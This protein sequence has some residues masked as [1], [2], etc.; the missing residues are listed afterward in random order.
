[1]GR[2]AV[3]ALLT[4]GLL[5][6]AGCGGSSASSMTTQT[7]GAADDPHTKSPFAAPLLP[8]SVQNAPPIR[9]RNQHGRVV[10]LAQYRGRAV[11]LTFV[12][13]HCLDVCPVILQ[14]LGAAQRELGARAH[15]M[16]ILAVSVDPRGD[17]PAYVRRFL[18]QRHIGSQVQYLLGTKAQLAPVWR[19]YNVPVTAEGKT[20]VGHL[21]LVI[22]I[23]AAG[24]IRTL[25]PATPLHTRDITHDAPLLAAA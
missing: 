10:S 6:L 5:T 22:G 25:Y 19:R 12:Y 1:M 18:S 2:I 7:T 21:A 14:D 11:F 4:C 17:T 9:L 15:R 23:D 13:T 20:Q 3:L 24:R 8:A 16:Q